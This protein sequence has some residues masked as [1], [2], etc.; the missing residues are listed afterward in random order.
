MPLKLK[1]SLITEKDYLNQNTHLENLSML[2]FQISKK[3]V[4]VLVSSNLFPKFVFYKM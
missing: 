1:V 3:C 2:E 4:G